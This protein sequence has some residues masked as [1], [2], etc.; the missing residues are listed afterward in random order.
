MYLTT[1][2]CDNCLNELKIMH[3]NKYEYK[4]KFFFKKFCLYCQ[5]ETYFTKETT[6]WTK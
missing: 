6:K 5:K 1:Y 2:K 4:Y 3:K